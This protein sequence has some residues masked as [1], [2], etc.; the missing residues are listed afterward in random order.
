MYIAWSAYSFVKWYFHWPVYHE[1]DQLL[2]HRSRRIATVLL[3][4]ICTESK[5]LRNISYT[6][7]VL[8]DKNIFNLLLPVENYIQHNY[9]ESIFIDKKLPIMKF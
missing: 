1:V 8:Y 7:L 5:F 4:K 6:F 2:K 9:H 3:S